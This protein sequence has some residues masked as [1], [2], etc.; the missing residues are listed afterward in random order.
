M[1]ARLRLPGLLALALA[2]AAC[3]VQIE[4]VHAQSAG[5]AAPSPP[6]SVSWPVDLSGEFEVALHHDRIAAVRVELV[7]VT[8][9]GVRPGNEWGRLS[10]QLRVRPPG[11]PP[12]REVPLGDVVLDVREGA[13]AELEFGLRTS[14]RDTEG[15][16]FNQLLVEVLR[17]DGRLDVV[18]E[19]AGDHGAGALDLEVELD[20]QMGYRN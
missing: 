10:G 13:Q 11:A 2:A 17:D 19:G 1:G 18:L 12:S 7:T 4:I 20:F 9:R 5:V 6:L 15:V 3:I 8:V 16:T 14:P